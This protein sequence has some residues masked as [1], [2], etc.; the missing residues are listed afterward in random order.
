MYVK[1]GE[2]QFKK[3]MLSLPQVIHEK[4]VQNLGKYILIWNY[5]SI[6]TV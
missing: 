6:K 5:G 3:L 2:C 1:K 4:C